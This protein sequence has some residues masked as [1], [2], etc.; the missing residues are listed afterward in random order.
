MK[1]I[2][3]FLLLFIALKRSNAQHERGDIVKYKIK[4]VTE[5][6]WNEDSTEKQEVKNYYSKKGNDSLIFFQNELAFHFKEFIDEKGRVGRLERYDAK[7]NLD[8]LHM[9][10]YE[11]DGTYSIEVIA[12]GAGTILESKF[13]KN[14]ICVQEIYS[15]IDT[16]EYKL[17]IYGKPEKIIY[18]SKNGKPQIVAEY[19]YN[20]E[21]V[22]QKI[23]EIKESRMR[24]FFYN[25]DSLISEIKEIEKDD[26]GK[27]ILQSVYYKYE[28]WR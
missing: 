26:S 25:S 6:R 10:E 24:G 20:S 7:N 18:K 5:L 23:Q 13:N 21:G 19:Y 15:G 2:F 1:N 14:N 3:L 4:S 28:M 27:E 22:L 17:D 16:L 11:K 8:E 9:F 12:H